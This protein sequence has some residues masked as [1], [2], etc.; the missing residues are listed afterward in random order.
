MRSGGGSEPLSEGDGR[1]CRGDGRQSPVDSKS[2]PK[3]DKARLGTGIQVRTTDQQ[4]LPCKAES[5]AAPP[6]GKLTAEFLA[7]SASLSHRQLMSDRERAYDSNDADIQHK[8]LKVREGF[9]RSNSSSGA[10]SAPLVSEQ[11]ADS[12]FF[13][14]RPRCS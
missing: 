9:T 5:E 2:H 8:L 4:T 7:V 12:N 6:G 14:R 11:N 3:V 10:L 1:A 13:L